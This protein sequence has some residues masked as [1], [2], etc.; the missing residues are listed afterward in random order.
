MGGSVVGG[1]GRFTDADDGMEGPVNCANAEPAHKHSSRN[2]IAAIRLLRKPLLCSLA[3]CWTVVAAV[4]VSRLR[5]ISQ[6]P[7]RCASLLPMQIATPSS[8]DPHSS[9]SSRNIH[10][11]HSIQ[12]S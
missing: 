2:V 3:T 12:A 6:P 7:Q 10:S 1:I 5:L 4:R 8:E 11:I 9:R